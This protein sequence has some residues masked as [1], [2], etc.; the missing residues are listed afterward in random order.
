MQH[1]DMPPSLTGLAHAAG[2]N[3]YKLKKGFK[4]LFNN[5]V[6]GYLSDYRLEN[7]K[8]ALAEKQKTATEIAFDLGYLRSSTSALHSKRSFGVSPTGK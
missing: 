4:E 2:I 3:E 5:T 6:F 8:L 1:I 7:A